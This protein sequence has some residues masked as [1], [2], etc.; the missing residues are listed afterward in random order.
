MAVDS[1][2]WPDTWNTALPSGS[3]SRREGDDNFNHIKEVVTRCLADISGNDLDES[4][5]TK[6]FP[7][8]VFS[9]GNDTVASSPDDNVGGTWV[10]FYDLCA[11]PP[12]SLTNGVEPTWANMVKIRVWARTP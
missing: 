11:H 3:D 5:F 2:L 7:V 4:I 8:G 6:L 12:G 10:H 1:G 9:V